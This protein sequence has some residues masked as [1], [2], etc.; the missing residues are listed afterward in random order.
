MNAAFGEEF[1][2]L[3]ADAFDHAHFGCKTECHLHFFISFPRE[4]SRDLAYLR[5][6]P[7]SGGAKDKRSVAIV[8]RASWEKSGS[9]T[10]A[11]I[12]TPTRFFVNIATKGVTSPLSPLDATLTGSHRH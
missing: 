2:A 9:K 7:E 3:R 11:L 6:P 4:M 12:G 5:C 1:C 10:A 8:I